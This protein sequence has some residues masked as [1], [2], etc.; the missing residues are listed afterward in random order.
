MQPHC[1]PIEISN[2]RLVAAAVERRGIWSSLV[3]SI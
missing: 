1:A 3:V 2:P